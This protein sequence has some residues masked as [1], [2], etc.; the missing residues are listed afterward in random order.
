MAQ[1]DV[2]VNTNR[3][4]RKIY[5]FLVDIQHDALS[6]LSTRLV[7]P[8]VDASKKPGMTRAKLTPEIVI[9]EASFIFMTPQLAAVPAELLQ[10]PFGSLTHSQ[11]L[12]VD[13]IDFIVTGI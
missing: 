7:V 5:P 10:A 3:N 4:S 9:D 11:H 2:Y 12:L 13:A 6:H 8:L 1:F